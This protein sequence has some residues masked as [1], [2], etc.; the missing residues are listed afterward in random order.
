MVRSLGLRN[1]TKNIVYHHLV[2]SC[3]KSRNQ[4]TED[5]IDT[6]KYRKNKEDAFEEE[7]TWSLFFFNNAYYV[8][9]HPNDH[10][11]QL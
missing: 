7:P 4:S 6:I 1:Q 5:E 9:S 10:R 3:S 2:F 8:Y 11:Y